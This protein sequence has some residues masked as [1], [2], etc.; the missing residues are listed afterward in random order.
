MSLRLTYL[1]GTK[2]VVIYRGSN[3]LHIHIIYI[4]IHYI[5]T[6]IYLYY[7]NRIFQYLKKRLTNTSYSM[8]VLLSYGNITQ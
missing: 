1:K 3:K 2:H 5:Y 4:H 8:K 6:Y 7:I